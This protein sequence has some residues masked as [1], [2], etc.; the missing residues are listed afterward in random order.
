MVSKTFDCF[1][2]TLLIYYTIVF[3]ELVIATMRNAPI[4]FNKVFKCNEGNKCPASATR[5]Q[6]Y[7]SVVKLYLSNLIH[8]M[9][10]LTDSGMLYVA[11]REAEKCSAYWTCYEKYAKDYLKVCDFLDEKKKA[12]LFFS[13]RDALDFAKLVVQPFFE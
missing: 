5:W 2:A 11:V 13:K 3:N 8:L 4:V 9:T 6:Y 1:K 7:N 12:Q 10:G